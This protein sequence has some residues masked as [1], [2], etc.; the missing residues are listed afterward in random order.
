MQE[1]CP[2]EATDDANDMITYG[3]FK[4][5]WNYEGHECPGPE[6][7]SRLIR[8]VQ[9]PSGG[10]VV[11]GW[12]CRWQIATPRCTSSMRDRPFLRRSV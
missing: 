2:W 1:D 8:T 12:S 11:A 6:I 5:A 10:T 4:E 7:F 3:D 9:R